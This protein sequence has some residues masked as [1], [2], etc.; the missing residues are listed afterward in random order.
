MDDLN[1]ELAADVDDDV[2]TDVAIDDVANDDKLTD[3][4]GGGDDDVTTCHSIMGPIQTWAKNRPAIRFNFQ[5]IQKTTHI[6][7]N[8]PYLYRFKTTQY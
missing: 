8:P 6:N 3:G 1:D 4:S 2:A 7:F 5:L